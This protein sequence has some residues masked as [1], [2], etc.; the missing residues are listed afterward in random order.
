[1]L[2]GLRAA[3]N[4]RRSGVNLTLISYEDV[5]A[6]PLSAVTRIVGDEASSIA[7]LQ[8][9][10]DAI[11]AADSQADHR[12]ARSSLSRDEAREGVWLKAFDAAWE[13]ANS[14]ELLSDLGVKI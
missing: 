2:Q 7:D 12:L 5:L 9:R 1:M 10:V 8:S 6:D 14:A 11:M 4:L 13:E 3:L